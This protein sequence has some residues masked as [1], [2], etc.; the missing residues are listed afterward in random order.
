MGT[1]KKVMAINTSF[2][3]L[4]TKILRKYIELW[5]EIK[6]LIER[7]DNKQVNMEKIL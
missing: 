7:I 5:D 2:L 1:L 6:N 3:L 4:Q